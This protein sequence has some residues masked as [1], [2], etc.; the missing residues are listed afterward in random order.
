MITSVCLTDMELWPAMKP[1]AERVD[2]PGLTEG[3]PSA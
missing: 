3:K 1:S 2:Q